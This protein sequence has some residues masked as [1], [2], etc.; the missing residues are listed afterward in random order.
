MP[1]LSMPVKVVKMAADNLIKVNYSSYLY[2]YF[3]MNKKLSNKKKVAYE[4]IDTSNDLIF[5]QEMPPA[6]QRVEDAC[7]SLQDA[8]VLL[9]N[10]PKSVNGKMRLIEGE[11]GE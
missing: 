8:T 6:L 1:D 9:K 11:R 5:K 3:K 4:T 7:L 10:D 2:S